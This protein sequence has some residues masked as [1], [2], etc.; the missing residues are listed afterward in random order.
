M[1][2]WRYRNPRI[3]GGGLPL[4]T[5]GFV[6]VGSRYLWGGFFFL[7]VSIF[8]SSHVHVVSLSN[9]TQFPDGVDFS[10]KEPYLSNPPFSPFIPSLPSV[11]L[12]Q[13]SLSIST[14]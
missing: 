5:R 6:L 12:C 8:L 3:L 14:G 7:F 2:T 11:I 13:D 1:V 9:L 4:S 10:R